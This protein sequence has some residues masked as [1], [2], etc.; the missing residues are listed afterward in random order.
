MKRILLFWLLSCLCLST[1]AQELI[2]GEQQILNGFLASYKADDLPKG[3]SKKT[4]DF[5]TQKY[6][7]TGF[8]TKGALTEGQC[9]EFYD[10]SDLPCLILEGKVSYLAGRLVITG[11]KYDKVASGSIARMECFKSLILLSNR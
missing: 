7:V 10:N 1:A 8:F 11:V 2:P 9:V 6:A 5:P 3:A 4:I